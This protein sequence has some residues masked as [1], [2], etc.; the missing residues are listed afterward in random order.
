MQFMCFCHLN[1]K[2][3]NTDPHVFSQVVSCGVTKHI[4]Y[5]SG[6]YQNISATLQ[7]AVFMLRSNE[8]IGEETGKCGPTYSILITVSGTKLCQKD[9]EYGFILPIQ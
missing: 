4:L 5:C 3:N 8:N 2:I 9:M 7:F 1:F 6:T